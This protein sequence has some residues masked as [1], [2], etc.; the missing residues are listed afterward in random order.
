MLKPLENITYLRCRRAI[1]QFIKYCMVGASGFVI[2]LFVFWLML[3]SLDVH[4]WIAGSVSFAVSVTNNFFMNRY[5]TF[6]ITEGEIFSQ[7]S[8]FMVVSISSWALNM[9]ML[10]LL[11]EDAK[12]NHYVAQTIAIA[13]VTILNFLGNKLWSFRQPTV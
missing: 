10:R 1:K 9:F 13:M 3:T 5:W 2:N 11:I 6:R 8:R 12:L 4:Y 7:A